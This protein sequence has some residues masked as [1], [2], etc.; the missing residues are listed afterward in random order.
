MDQN[1]DIIN[2]SAVAE[3]V[4]G[5]DRSVEVC[6]VSGSE[7]ALIIT[8][9]YARQR[10]PILVVVPSMEEGQRLVEDLRFFSRQQ[11]VPILF[12][13]SYHL[14]PFKFLS[15][16][17]ETAAERIRVL[18][19]MMMDDVPPVVVVP[20][21]ALL[22]RLVPRE[23]ISRYA[24]LV[25]EGEEVDRERL[26]SKLISGGYLRTAIVEE[27]GDFSVRG[28]IVDVFS[29]L[30]PDPLRIELFG[31]RVESLRFFSAGDQR[32]IGAVNEAVLLPAREAILKPDALPE[33]LNR[34]RLQAADL[35]LPPTQVRKITT[36]LSHQ[37]T[38]PGIESLLSL[39]YPRL[40][41][42]FDYL[43][44]DAL[45]VAAGPE[46]LEGAAAEFEEL[47]RTTYA[48][49]RENR[50]FCAPPESL[51]LPWEEVRGLMAGR[52]P[53]ALKLLEVAK[54]GGGVEASEARVVTVDVQSNSQLTAGLRQHRDKDQLLLPLA[55][56]IRDQQR[57]GRRVIVVCRSKSPAERL[58]SL[59]APYG[60]HFQRSEGFPAPAA[61]PSTAIVCLG[62]VT[63]GFVWPA[64]R[65]AVVSEDEI[66][67]VR[68]IRRAKPDAKARIRLL[69]LQELKQ[70]DLIVHTE[71][72]IGRY[73]GLQKLSVEGVRNDFLALTYHGGDK[74]YLPVDRMGMVQKYMGVEGRTPGLD[75]LGGKSWE[76]VK[77]RVK[78]S[79]EK[80]AGELLK[81]YAQRKVETGF[82]FTSA[83]GYFRDFEA[84]F[85]YEETPDQ[86]KVID[87]VLED[88]QQSVPMDRLVCGDVGYGKTEVALRASFLA[89]N[90]GKQVAVL[91]PTTILAE[92]HYATFRSRFQRHP[93]N[94]ACLSRFR[95][96]KE[97]QAIVEGL[98]SGGVDI[99]IGTHRL[100]QKDIV[101][102]D[103][104][105]LVLDEE[106]R[107]G[108]R[109][110]EKLKRLR[111]TV[112]VLALTAT[113]IPRTLH[114]S[115]MGVRDISLIQTP[116]EYRKAIIS[117]I[118]EFDPDVVAQAIRREL[119][120]RGQIYFVHNA[121]H[122]IPA[123]ARKLQEL[124]PE[125]RLDIAHGQ[126]AEEELER[127]MVRF[128]NR[129]IDLLVCTTII[130]SGLDIPTA[131]TIIVNRADCFGLAQMYQL[132][133]RVGR[134]DEQAYAYLLI[135]DESR[136]TADARKRLK[137]LMEHSDLGSGFNIAM[138]DL[139]IRGGGTILGASQS[140]HI[141]AVGYDMFLK[142]MEDAVADLKGEPVVEPLDPEI[143]IPLSAYFAESYIPDID[144]RMMLYRRLARMNGLQEIADM[145]SELADRFGPL[146]DEA[147]HLL[148]K[149][150]LKVL[151]RYAGVSRLDL[152]NQ[153][154]VLCFS[155]RHP[156]NVDAVVKMVLDD[157]ER[158]EMSPGGVVKA[159][160]TQ[161][162]A[163]GQLAQAKN[164]LQAIGQRV[165][166]QEN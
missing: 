41:G 47:A 75:K 9:I 82:A 131:N 117:Y 39:I 27:P 102:K 166:S 68:H 123:M 109:H 1:Q 145:R 54:A 157:P 43:P 64:E 26:V 92:Q 107:F 135:P 138:N 80:M 113:P 5:R 134:S 18:Y 112:D 101:F 53:V 10:T 97:Q 149:I 23:E 35:N 130:E 146:P 140:G 159:R 34:I 150:M 98:R 72:G 153:K 31:D 76:R 33:I 104:G 125:V 16:H 160:L 63:N 85:A 163:A 4:A 25:M 56:W 50:S 78:R 96:R 67:G 99:V 11:P 165:N 144:Q 15:Y 93:V 71:H 38:F 21:Q 22:Q 2:A 58:M 24:E 42:L 46:Q 127:V 89:V 37:E 122:S 45:C 14:L 86:L 52:R 13:P 164:I 141:A 51:Y 154:L 137:V 88:M 156:K 103:L 121:I 48:G 139:E 57:L 44:A 40:E 60:L 66:F 143:N 7:R 95:P 118:S 70:G 129:D 20:V 3:A 6:G 73:E 151:A 69:D 29:P 119:R 142:L 108:V 77:A 59:L 84:G 8:A 32:H 100:I 152:N 106:Q 110:K 105:L 81:L 74:L 62:Q 65:L 147:T 158:F 162:G 116:P 120:R 114:M 28:G 136:L 19:R 87:Q 148:F 94:I 133:G 161:H 111:S 36:N 83:D 115:L 90:N 155:D 126:M 132:R 17:N 55:D 49:A 124:V 91:V 61:E 12:F 128:L 30:Y 79:A